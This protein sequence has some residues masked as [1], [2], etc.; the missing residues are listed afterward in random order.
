[1]YVVLFNDGS[2]LFLNAISCLSFLF[3]MNIVLIIACEG[4]SDV[5]P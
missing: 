4:G 2:F 5:K 1:M 3:S